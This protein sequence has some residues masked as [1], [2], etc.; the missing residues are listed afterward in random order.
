MSSKA[1]KFFADIVEMLKFPPKFEVVTK[2]IMAECVE[3]HLEKGELDKFHEALKLGN[4]L[5]EVDGK[6]AVRFL[7]P[8]RKFYN[9]I[10]LAWFSIKPSSLN[11]LEPQRF[12]KLSH[13]FYE[14]N[15]WAW[16]KK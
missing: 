16:K 6:I 10:I 13:D 1:Q 5:E 12:L 2:H 4:S 8:K 3:V 11:S 7:K 9:N 14:K 15:K